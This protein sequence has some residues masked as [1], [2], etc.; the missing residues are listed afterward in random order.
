MLRVELLQKNIL[1]KY[2]KM[3]YEFDKRVMCSEYSAKHKN[4]MIETFFFMSLQDKIRFN[5]DQFRDTYLGMFD[6]TFSYLAFHYSPPI[7]D[8]FT[9]HFQK[10]PVDRQIKIMTNNE[11]L[12]NVVAQIK[13]T[14]FSQIKKTRL[15]Q[16]RVIFI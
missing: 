8:I 1:R 12:F 10:T 5:N 15:S 9:R 4:D 13:K 11:T 16:Q 2:N 6:N 7:V 14:R 3:V